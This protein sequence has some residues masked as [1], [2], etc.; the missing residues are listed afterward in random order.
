MFNTG[1]EVGTVKC[2]QKDIEFAVFHE[3]D[4]EHERDKLLSSGYT[5]YVWVSDRSI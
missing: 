5:T 1:W 3:S 2:V 4:Q